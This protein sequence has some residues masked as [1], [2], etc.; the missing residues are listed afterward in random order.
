MSDYLIIITADENDADYV[1][2]E[3][4]VNAQDFK[5]IKILL[6]KVAEAIKAKNVD[7]DWYKNKWPMRYIDGDFSF[8]E[9][10]EDDGEEYPFALYKMYENYL[11]RGEIDAFNK[12]VGSSEYGV[13][14][15]KSIEAYPVKKVIKFL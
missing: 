2:K 15:I 9:D 8:D 5:Q 3:T 12:Y 6:E 1:R 13:H 11:T 7:S 14:T 10:N 4:L